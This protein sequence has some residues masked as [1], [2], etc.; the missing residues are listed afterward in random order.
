MS[1]R[2][3]SRSSVPW[4]RATTWAAFNFYLDALRNDVPLTLG[5]DDEVW[6]RDIQRAI[7]W[8]TAARGEEGDAPEDI[9]IRDEAGRVVGR[10]EGG[11]T[12]N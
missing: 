2:P 10:I 1:P 11:V 12:P 3:D 6:H 4:N 7:G 8:H 9:V 5:E